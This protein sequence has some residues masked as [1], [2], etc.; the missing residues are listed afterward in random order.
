MVS[1]HN[2]KLAGSVQFAP[3]PKNLLCVVCES[4]AF[5]AVK[6]FVTAR[7]TTQSQTTHQMKLSLYSS[8]QVFDAPLA[9]RYPKE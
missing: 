7:P 5:F 6:F 1:E 8:S 2:R 9:G 3:W 4:L